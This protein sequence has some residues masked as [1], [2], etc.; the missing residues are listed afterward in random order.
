MG[1]E[2]PERVIVKAALVEDEMPLLPADTDD[3]Q[4]GFNKTNSPGNFAVV[5]IVTLG[6]LFDFDKE[7]ALFDDVND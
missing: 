3:L 7:G 4:V 5:S 2:G 1:D 6:D